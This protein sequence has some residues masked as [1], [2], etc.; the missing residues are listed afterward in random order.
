MPSYGKVWNVCVSD[1]H[2]YVSFTVDKFW[3]F[4][5]CNMIWTSSVAEKIEIIP[6]SKSSLYRSKYEADITVFVVS[7]IT[8]TMG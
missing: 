2:R 8:R 1:D 5:M 6:L 7:F 4:N 3:V